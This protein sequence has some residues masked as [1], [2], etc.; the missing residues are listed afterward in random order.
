MLLSA[1]GGHLSAPS[2]TAPDSDWVSRWKLITHLSGSHY[3]LPRGQCG[4]RYVS[5]LTDEINL[6]TR[7]AFPSERAIVFSSVILQRDKSVRGSRDIV[8]TLN[9]RLD[10]WAQKKYDLVQE[11]SRCDRTY[12]N[13]RHRQDHRDDDHIERVFTRLM[14][15]GKVRAAMR[16]L[17]S[18]SK[19]HVLSPSDTTS[20]TVNGQI[21]Q[22]PVIDILKSKHPSLHPPHSSTLLS[23]PSPLPL[24]EDLDVTGTH[25]SLIAKRLQGSAGPGGC[26]SSH[27]QNI[28][29][30]YGSHSRLLCDSIAGLTR[31][32]SNSLVDW[33]HIQALLANCLIA[34]DKSPGVRPIGIGE[35]LR[36]LIGKVICFL[37]REDAEAVCG[38]SQLCAGL[39]CGAE[40]AIHVAGDLFEAGG[41]SHGM[42]VMDAE[43][44]F[45][46]INRTALLW[47][48]RILWPHAS[49]FVF[50]TYRGWS[51]LII[52]G[53]DVGLYS[54]EGVIQGD[55]LSMFLYAL[56]TLPL[57]NQLQSDPSITQ[58]WYADDSCCGL[59]LLPTAL[60]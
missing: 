11:A 21:K 33:S 5:T 3:F 22:V 13:N 41:D 54:S 20:I 16:W 30:R 51:P 53:H 49:R 46:S 1:Y 19:G 23:P 55:P 42:L 44:A 59:F 4:R 28:L 7:G 39:R 56:A 29:L 18:R 38:V 48:I 47:N 52:K 6:L 25:I 32:L 2:S 50:N 10:L 37:I 36:R 15:L 12:R 26:D 14:L 45:N 58:L 24:F 17:T 43:N 60:V 40:G 8:R 35:S 27:W 57:I 31:S 34:L 9:R